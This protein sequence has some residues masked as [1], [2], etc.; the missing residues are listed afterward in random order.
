[1]TSRYQ[2]FVKQHMPSA[3]GKTFSEKIKHV[4]AAWRRQNPAKKVEVKKRQR[5]KGKGVQE[6][7][8]PLKEIA[9]KAVRQGGAIRGASSKAHP[10]FD[11]VAKK[12][13]KRSGE[14][15]ANAKAML[16][17]STRRDSSAA[18]RANPRLKKVKGGAIMGA[19]SK[20][21]SK[22]GYK[23]RNFSAKNPG[24]VK[25]ILGPVMHEGRPVKRKPTATDRRNKSRVKPL[26]GSAIM[27]GKAG[28]KVDLGSMIQAGLRFLQG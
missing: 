9:K 2:E 5:T 18:K 4:A 6:L 13:A 23:K 27:G 10:G 11:A 12:I 1:M 24:P 7:H 3:K 21:K 15:I 14:P 20:K 28:R 19:G 26:S 22:G 17:A 8:L 25:K 16:A